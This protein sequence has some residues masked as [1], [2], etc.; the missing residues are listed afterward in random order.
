[1]SGIRGKNTKPEL[2]LRRALHRLGLR[3]R[4]HVAGLPGRPDVVSAKYRAII[5]VQGCFWHRHDHCA[6]ATTPSSNEP[7]WTAK[8]EE[9]KKRDQRN[10]EA[11]RQLGWRVALIWE[12][13]LRQEGAEHV[14]QKVMDWLRS[15]RPFLELSK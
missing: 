1:M 8:F 2:V 13:S 11:L 9:T 5:Q 6:Y 10:L 14:A 12:C 7:F 3:F 4:I 15:S